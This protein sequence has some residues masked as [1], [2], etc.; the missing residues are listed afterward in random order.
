MKI[1]RVRRQLRSCYAVHVIVWV[2]HN[3]RIPVAIVSLTENLCGGRVIDVEIC[4][5]VFAKIR[6]DFPLASATRVRTT[7]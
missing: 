3:Y 4:N 5:Y 7:S 1:R 6:I 2:H